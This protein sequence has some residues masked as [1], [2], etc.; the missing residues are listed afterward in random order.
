MTKEA[1]PVKKK[2]RTRKAAVAEKVYFIRIK[3]LS[4]DI[5]AYVREEPKRNK[6]IVR[7]PLRIEV[8]TFLEENRQIMLMFEYLPQS[9]ITMDEIEFDKSEIQF[10]TPV[11]A[12]FEEHYVQISKYFYDRKT[13]IK[14]VVGKNTGGDVAQELTTTDAQKVVSILEALNK[15]DKP[16]H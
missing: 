13:V 11:R 4:E 1:K 3:N 15:K 8:E 12:E 16:I 9:V 14:G 5:V 10:M 6:V 7:H 2:K